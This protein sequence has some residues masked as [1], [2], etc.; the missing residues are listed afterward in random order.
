M[1]NPIQLI[2]PSPYVVFD[3]KL[4]DSLCD[5]ICSYFSDK[6]VDMGKTVNNKGYRRAGIRWSSPGDWIGPFM[7]QY[8]SQVNETH[9]Q[10]DITGTYFGETHQIEYRPGCHYKWHEDDSISHCLMY[11][12]PGFHKFRPEI[13]EYMRKLSYTLQLSH[14]DDYTGGQVQ[15][16]DE[17]RKM[18]FF[19][20]KE[21][22]TLCIFDSRTRHRV[23]PV[24][25]GK[26]FAL[27]GWA[28]GPR[29]K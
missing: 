1:K 29:W 14:P 26:R 27:V 13:K 2:E 16:W 7:W 24:K 21:K 23:L 19:I 12:H 22:G 18:S 6:E 3:T 5:D 9:F 4:P 15:L 10:Y 8:L 17:S 28:V 25:E 11:E 20:P